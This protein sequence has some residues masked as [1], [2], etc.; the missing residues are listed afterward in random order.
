MAAKLTD[1]KSGRQI[2]VHTT[3]PGVQIYTSNFLS[4]DEANYPFI[5][6]NAICLETQNFPDAVN[7]SHFPNAILKVGEVYDHDTV[8]QFRIAND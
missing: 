5:Q 1:F 7:Q 2:I 8:I 6:H 4:E 3:Q